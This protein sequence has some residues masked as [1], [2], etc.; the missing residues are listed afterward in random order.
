[1]FG[2]CVLVK[3]A[4]RDLR[5]PVR[6]RQLKRYIGAS[7]GNGQQ[8]RDQWNERFAVV[9][10]PID[11]SINLF[12][13][14]FTSAMATTTSVYLGSSWLYPIVVRVVRSVLV[15]VLAAIRVLCCDEYRTKYNQ[16]MSFVSF[17]FV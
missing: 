14:R 10:K 3:I 5:A 2:C 7:A 12:V 15:V 11:Q 4:Q 13:Q 9:L 16:L 6:L 8:C 17:R 1:M